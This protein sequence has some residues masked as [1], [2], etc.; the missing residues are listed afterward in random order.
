[1]KLEKCEFMCEKM[2]YLGF[3]VRYGSCKTCK[4]VMTLRKVFTKFGVLFART[5]FTGA[6]YKILHIHL[7]Q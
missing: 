6:I 5:I 4:Y 3:D 2:E 1:M 7:P